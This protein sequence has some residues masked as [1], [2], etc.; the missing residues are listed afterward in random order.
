MSNIQQTFKNRAEALRFVRDWGFPFS[1]R[2]FYDDCVKNDLLNQ[3]GKSINL[4]SLIKYLWGMYPPVP[5]SSDQVDA[6]AQRVF[7]RERLEDRKLLAEVES[8]ERKGRKEDAAWMEVVDRDRQMAAF[9]GLIETA[10]NQES[11]LKLSELI[12]LCEGNINKAAKFAHG[13]SALFAAALTEAV[14]DSEMDVEFEED[15]STGS[16]EDTEEN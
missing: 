5:S 16:Q 9:A 10:L 4:N 8:L 2:K 15:E 13:L 3:D 14:R 1:E 7:G 6:D 12:Y 11:T